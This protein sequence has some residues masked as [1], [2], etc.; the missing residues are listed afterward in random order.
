MA[1]FVTER[2]LAVAEE[3]F[4]GITALFMALS[5]EARPMTFLHLLKL[6][7]EREHGRGD[8]SS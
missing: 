5:G 4:P 7:I 3:E 1:G 6:W 8:A 2:D